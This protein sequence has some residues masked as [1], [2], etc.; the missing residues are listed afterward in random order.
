LISIRK[1]V[2][3][4]ERLDEIE[5]RENLANTIL[6]CYALAI[7]SSAHYVVEVDPAHAAEFRKHLAVI[8]DQSRSAVSVDQVRAAQASFRGELREYRDKSAEQLKKL[9]QEMADASAAMMVFAATVTSNGED[10]EQQVSSQLKSLEGAAKSLQIEEIRGGIG[11]AIAGIQSSVEQIQRGNQ[12][13]VVQL[14]DEIR[15]LHR[16]I[17]EE[18]KALYTD[19]ASGA[20]NRSKID[21]HID[22]LL[23][24][25]QAFCLLMVRVRNLK[26]IE[27][28]HSH[29]VLEGTLKAMV[30]RFSALIGNDAVIGR[31]SPDQF[32]AVLDL[33]PAQ[34]TSLSSEA[35]GKLSGVYAVQEN[36]Q[37]LK[38]TVQATTGVIDRAS[39]SPADTFHRRLEQLTSAISG[40]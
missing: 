12:L 10:H 11:A 15:A 26:R 1:S 20:W 9:R 13:V 19:R 16:Q 38:V 14:Q 34:A 35:Y 30:A 6:E 40:A 3:D 31:W 28:Q 2:D 36:G 27:G 21:T 8:E 24:Q 22:N 37:S 29:A 33:L 25:N 7:H 39:G 32:V 17:E 4:L 18:R 5:K 23:R